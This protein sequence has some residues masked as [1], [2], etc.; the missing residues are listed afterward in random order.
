MTTVTIDLPDHQAAALSQQAAA[1]GVSLRDR[2]ARQLPRACCA[3]NVSPLLREL[4]LACVALGALSA[5]DPAHRR[6]AG[7]LFDHLKTLPTVPLQLPPPKDP[8]AVRLAQILR[9]TPGVSL[10]AAALACRTSLRTLERLFREETHLPL[11][12]W[13]RR[14]RLQLALERLAAGAT[15]TEAARHSGYNG[16]GAFISMFRRELGVTPNQ[17]LA[18]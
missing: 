13:F 9:Q 4:I 7:V 2:Q 17:Y 14:L 3:V 6:L 15:V 5:L 12:A 8:R 16:P 1:Q 10:S 11:G 18:N